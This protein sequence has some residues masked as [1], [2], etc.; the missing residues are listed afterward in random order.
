MMTN[1]IQW[2]TEISPEEAL[3]KTLAGALV[4]DLRELTEVDK[5]VPDVPHLLHF[6]LSRFEERFMELPRDKELILVCKNG[7]QSLRAAYVLMQHGF[8][9]VVSMQ[10]GLIRWVQNG[11]PTK[12]NTNDV[13]KGQPRTDGNARASLSIDSMPGR[14]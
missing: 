4:V 3:E 1:K 7:G 9:N 12:G 13:L 14:H 8:E 10:H 2:A 11:L 5:L 6:P